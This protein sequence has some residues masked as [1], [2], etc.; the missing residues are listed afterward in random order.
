MKRTSFLTLGLILLAGLL[1]QL[2][3]P[4]SASQP[5]QAMYYTPTPRPDGRIIYI[6]KQN[7]TCISISLLNLI[8]EQ[9]LRELNNIKGE[10]CLIRVGQELL[11]GLSGPAVSPT[12]GPSP[13]ATVALPTPTPLPGKGKICLL[14]F[15]DINGN[16]FPEETETALPGGAISVTHKQG[17]FSN[18]VNTTENDLVTPPCFEDIP[19][20]EYTISAAVPQGYNPTT[21]TSYT[22][23]LRSGDISTLDFG[24][25]ASAKN[26]PAG[27]SGE[28][29]SPLLGI[30]GGL[31]L[32]AGIGAGLFFLR[33]KR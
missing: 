5:P 24:A 2:A 31:L 16:G 25:Q 26:P 20:G 13:T 4:V 32:L 19:E 27:T 30:L 3:R 12:P 6:V 10:N 22:L 17:K 14:M 21:G 28:Q 29:T 15:E 23:K 11:L 18:T 7:D 33:M 1:L 8:S 9:K